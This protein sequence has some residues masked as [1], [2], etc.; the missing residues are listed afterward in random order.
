MNECDSVE[1]GEKFL[2]LVC[3]V[4]VVF[5]GFVDGFN[6]GWERKRGR[7]DFKVFREN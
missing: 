2:D 7:D 4:R 1:L 3:F 5:I 6:E